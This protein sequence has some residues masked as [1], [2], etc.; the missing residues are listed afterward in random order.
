VTGVGVK[1]T[2]TREANMLDVLF[3]LGRTR[4]IDCDAICSLLIECLQDVST[5]AFALHHLVIYYLAS[6][7]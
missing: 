1:T 7:F 3:V 5:I 4:A 6:N 2:H